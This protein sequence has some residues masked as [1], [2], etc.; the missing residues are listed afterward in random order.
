MMYPLVRELAADR[1]PVA[2][3]CRVLGFRSARRRRR[4]RRRARTPGPHPRG[5][6]VVLDG[7]GHNAHLEQPGITNALVRDWLAQI[8]R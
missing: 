5:S 2:M 6:F 3:T 4:L 1:I 8:D 7:A